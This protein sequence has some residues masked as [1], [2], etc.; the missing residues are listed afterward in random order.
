[1]IKAIVMDMD[2][3]L[4]DPNNKILN[5]TKEALI[6]LEKQ[7][8][9]LILASG[10]SYTRL[11]PYAKELLMDQYNGYLIEVDGISIYD[12]G[13]NERHVLKT[14][15]EKD[16]EIIFPYLMS[17]D[18]E[19]MACFDDGMFDYIP[20]SIYKIK[21]ELRKEM[22]VSDDFP[23]TGGPW[24]WLADTRDGYPKITYLKSWHEIQGPINKIQILQEEKNLKKYYEEIKQHFQGQ[25]EI[26]RTCPRQL[27][28]L[29]LGYD[30]GKTL[31]RIMQE[32]HW[33]QD[34]VLAFGDGENDVSMFDYV[35]YGF[36]MGQAREYVKEKAAFITSSNIEQGIYAALKKLNLV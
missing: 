20:E 32:N 13:K 24:G 12:L 31:S 3:T 6:H 4:L 28:I 18:I 16:M 36:A 7:G 11:I 25:Y 30:K 8:V 9:R 27:E 1:M 34:E 22:N 21:A 10:R 29:P 19:S 23:W 2:G 14:M 17:L 33:S 26:F 35:T 15:D 5:E